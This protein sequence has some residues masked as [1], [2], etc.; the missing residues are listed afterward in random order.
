MTLSMWARPAHGINSFSP[1]S[2][3]LASSSSPA[4]W[5]S[6]EEKMSEKILSNWPQLSQ[7]QQQLLSFFLLFHLKSETKHF[8]GHHQDKSEVDMLHV[9]SSLI[10][11]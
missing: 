11:S 5:V 2:A 3:Y 4:D 1:S 10:S 6:L 8:S 9:W 7:K